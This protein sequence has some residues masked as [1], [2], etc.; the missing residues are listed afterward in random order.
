[1]SYR[2]QDVELGWEYTLPV[3][4][5]N[6]T[7]EAREISKENVYATFTKSE[8]LFQKNGAVNIPGEFLVTIWLSLTVKIIPLKKENLYDHRVLITK[9]DK[10]GKILDKFECLVSTKRLISLLYP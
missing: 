1:M 8:N 10:T 3:R 7:I 5:F 9:E 6:Y 4:Q 2:I